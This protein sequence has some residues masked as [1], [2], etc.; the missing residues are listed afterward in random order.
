M[1]GA[2]VTINEGDISVNASDDGINAAGGSSG[3]EEQEGQFGADSFGEPGGGQ[4]GGG[5]DS[6]KF[7]EI[8]GGTTYVNA[9]GDGID[10]NG[11]VR[12]TAGTL[13]VNGPTDDGNGALD[14]D[15]TFTMDGGIFLLQAVV[16]G[17]Q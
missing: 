7:I 9:D 2:T 11:D 6:T 14:Y 15:G 3:E 16:L 4:P 10:S 12:M 5:G 17:W 13:I 8:N 1:E